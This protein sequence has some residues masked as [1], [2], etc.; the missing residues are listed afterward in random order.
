MFLEY[1]GEVNEAEFIHRSSAVRN[2]IEETQLRFASRE[3]RP[4]RQALL[5]PLAIVEAM[6]EMVVCDD[7]KPFSRAYAWFRLV[8]I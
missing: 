2:A 5:I 4:S 1:A 8:K 6:E 3:I 7:A